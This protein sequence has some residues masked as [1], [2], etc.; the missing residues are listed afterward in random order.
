MSNIFRKGRK[1][2]RLLGMQIATTNLYFLS[3]CASPQYYTVIARGAEQQ[4]GI[5]SE[6]ECER[7]SQ[8]GKMCF[9]FWEKK[10]IFTS[11]Q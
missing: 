3:S 6:T 4:L 5:V 7:H 10:I 9:C 8:T 1:N 11:G 2:A